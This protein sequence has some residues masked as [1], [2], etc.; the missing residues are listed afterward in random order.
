MGMEKN[1][2]NKKKD[3]NKKKEDPIKKGLG[4]FIFHNSN[5]ISC[6][7]IKPFISN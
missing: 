1:E 4:W 2:S 6:L 3:R 7:P 5:T